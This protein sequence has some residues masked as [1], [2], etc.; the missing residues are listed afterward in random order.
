MS[1]RFKDFI[2]KYKIR[3]ITSAFYNSKAQRIVERSNRTSGDRLRPY[4]KK[5]NDWNANLKALI[6][7]INTNINK[8]TKETFLS[9]ARV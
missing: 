9:Y 4:T 1:N 6:F 3:H 5:T 8:I 2:K 7:A